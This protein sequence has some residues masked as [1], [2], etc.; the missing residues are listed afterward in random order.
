MSSNVVET[1]S[2]TR[3]AAAVAEE[4]AAGSRLAALREVP[5]WAMS[6]GVHLLLLVL[7]H[8]II[9]STPAESRVMID[10][11]IEELQ[12]DA[13]KFDT[14]I[15][16]QVGSDSPINTLSPSKAAATQAG[17]EP[18]K[19]LERQLESQ[20]QIQVPLSEPVFEPNEAEFVE[21]INTQGGSEHTGGVEGAI[22]RLTYE[23]AGSLK[24]RKTL[25][26]WLFDAS[27]SLKS[28]REA[29]ADR[30]ENVY[31]QLGQLDVGADRALKTAAVSFGKDLKFL[32]DEPVDDV[33]Q[34]AEAV[35]KIENDVSGE[36]HTFNAVRTVTRKWLSYRTKMRR[37][38]MLIIVT[39][40]RGDDY[41]LLEEVIQLN[42][43]YGI[44]VYCIG[45][46]AVFGRKE[47][48]VTWTYSDGST[49]KLPIDQGPE[50]VAP[51]RLKLP[52]WGTRAE[53]LELMSSSFGPY[54]LS[55]LCAET[56][57]MYFIA[58]ESLKVHFD[59]AV[60]RRYQP[61]YRPIKDY[62]RELQTNL[63]KGALVR[64]A[65]LTEVDDQGIPVPQTAFRADS[66][67]ILRQQI[68]EA[69]KPLAV[70]D[71]KLEEM[72]K[73][74]SAGEKARP[75][76]AESRWQAGYDLAMGRVLA[77]RARALGYNAMLAEMKAAPKPFEKKESNQWRLVPANEITS[78]PAVKKLAQQATEHLTR[79]VDEHPGTPWAL[80]AARE[81]SVPM[82]WGWKE[83]TM[84]IPEMRR[85][86]D[87]DDPRLLLA[88]EQRRREEQRKREE[89]QKRERPKL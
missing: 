83:A 60:M 53:D 28:R 5:A 70:L 80:L 34:V 8:N 36:E 76:L 19:E 39:D 31:K 4:P 84:V 2:W 77:L 13:L 62:E 6:L 69:Q 56:G 25:V 63:A 82:G 3:P 9:Y 15:T 40:E 41:E 85:G 55:R 45:N 49:E 35:R 38:M 65:T 58:E 57:G 21:M 64:A 48:L 27:L 11:A 24:E 32:T 52:F 7:L 22:D 12:Q 44:R 33:G 20:F 46:A 18:Q 73:I 66:D 88:E 43:R 74:L 89:L 79:V 81:L 50:T 59:P 10:S 42:R 72:H 17:E 26:V 30:F 71:Y 78:G 75:N 23:I 29:I 14:T 61:D 47:N 86:R 54:G 51:E 68:T 37:N 87:N 16:D 67:T 1:R